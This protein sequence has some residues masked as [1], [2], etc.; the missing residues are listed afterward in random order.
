[1][2][3]RRWTSLGVLVIAFVSTNAIAQLTGNSVSDP[4]AKLAQLGEDSLA[5]LFNL[6]SAIGAVAM[7]AGG[8]LVYLDFLPRAWLMKILVVTAL[9]VIGPQ[10]IKFIYTIAS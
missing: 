8:L 9:I 5:N 6:A 2:K 7:V 10:I 3:L 4:T 1:M